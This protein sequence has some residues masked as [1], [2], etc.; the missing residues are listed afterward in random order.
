MF[1]SHLNFFVGVRVDFFD[2]FGINIFWFAVFQ[3]FAC[4]FVG[5][6]NYWSVLRSGETLSV[7]SLRHEVLCLFVNPDIYLSVWRWLAT[8]PGRASPPL[9]P[10]R[11]P[12][13]MA[14]ATINLHIVMP[15]LFRGPEQNNATLDGLKLITA[16]YARVNNSSIVI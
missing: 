13:L 4:S 12:P 6:I 2:Q 5:W 8:A 7:H 11:S 9:M 14:H 10:R 16:F 1:V 3:V 15:Q